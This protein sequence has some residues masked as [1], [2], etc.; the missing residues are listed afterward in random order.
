MLQRVAALP[1]GTVIVF[2]SFLRD[3]DGD[4]FIPV[5]VLRAMSRVAP[6][7][8]YAVS[9]KLQNFQA[10]RDYYVLLYDVSVR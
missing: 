9:D 10:R 8:I 5:D 2:F 1:A 4:A 3:R 6:V 7:P